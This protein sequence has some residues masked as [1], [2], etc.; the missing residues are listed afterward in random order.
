MLIRGPT[1]TQNHKHSLFPGSNRFSQNWHPRAQRFLS[2]SPHHPLQLVSPLQQPSAHSV[3][4][5]HSK[6]PLLPK[7]CFSLGLKSSLVIASEEKQEIREHNLCFKSLAT[8]RA[9]HM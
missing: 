9:A 7:T 8:H 3:H 1:A 5:L 4:Y 6:P 2:A